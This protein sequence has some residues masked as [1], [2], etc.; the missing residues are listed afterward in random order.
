[1]LCLLKIF[2]LFFPVIIFSSTLELEFQCFIK[3]EIENNKL[4]TKKKYD[5]D[6][7]KL[8]LDK[9][10]NWLNDKKFNP[11]L[12]EDSHFLY[13][14]KETEENYISIKKNYYNIEK[15]KLESEDRLILN[16][17]SGSLEFVKNYYDNDKKVFFSSELLGICETNDLF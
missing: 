6:G 5:V 9:K 16:K 11:Y 3:K 4:T 7:I 2:I 8:F 1:M 13:S 14:L 10:N 15:N 17:I 12:S